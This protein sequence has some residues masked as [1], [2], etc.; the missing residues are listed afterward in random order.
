MIQDA[1]SHEIKSK[2][3]LAWKPIGT[4]IRGRPRKRWILGIEEDLQITGIKRWRKQS[5]ERAE[6]KRITGRPK[7]TMGSNASK[8][9]SRI[10]VKIKELY[11]YV[12]V[13]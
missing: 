10:R 9:R 3:I 1:R 6:W 2:R 11:C 7:S 5:E 13:H 12:R 4:R 8:R